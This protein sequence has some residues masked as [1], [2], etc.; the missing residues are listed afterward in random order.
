ME[1]SNCNCK[2]MQKPYGPADTGT[3]TQTNERV[4]CYAVESASTYF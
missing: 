4:W 3:G 1:C 2:Q